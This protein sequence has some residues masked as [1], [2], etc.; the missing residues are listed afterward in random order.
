MGL[1][2]D[3]K[4]MIKSFKFKLLL[5]LLVVLLLGCWMLAF[6]ASMDIFGSNFSGFCLLFF[7]PV[8]VYDNADTEK[9]KIITENKG[10]S[11]VY[12]RVNKEN[13]NSYLGSG[14]DLARRFYTYYSLRGMINYLKKFKN[15]IFRAILKYGHSKF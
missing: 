2:K 6:F 9:I 13:G 1:K 12:R 11:G 8:A 7:I 15:H 14:E 4:Q 3:Q 10:K 5:L